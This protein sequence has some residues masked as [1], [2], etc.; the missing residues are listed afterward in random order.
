MY[1][2]YATAMVLNNLLLGGDEVDGACVGLLL[3]MMTSSTVAHN[4]I[5]GGNCKDAYAIELGSNPDVSIVNNIL[6]VTGAGTPA[7]DRFGIF[8]VAEDESIPLAVK[9]N[10]IF[11]VDAM[12]HTFNDGDT[13]YRTIEEMDAL[14]GRETQRD[15]NCSYYWECGASQVEDNLTTALSLDE[16]FLDADGPDDDLYTFFDNNW[17]LKT[18]EPAIAE[19]GLDTTQALCGTAESPV[20]CGDVTGDLKG[21]PRPGTPSLGAYQ[22]E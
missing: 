9:N 3:D 20:S 21:I 18:R 13:N 8:E 6:F 12:Y 19:G 5:D 7:T 4:T 11:S 14:D 16:L 10:L 15:P 17:R 2:Y 22:V 1:R